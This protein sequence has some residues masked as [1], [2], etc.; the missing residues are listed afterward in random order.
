[1]WSGLPLLPAPPPAVRPQPVPQPWSLHTGM[2]N[3]SGAHSHTISNISSPSS[4]VCLLLPPGQL[5]PP[6]V[7]QERGGGGGDQ[8]EDAPLLQVQE[9]GGQAVPPSPAPLS[10]ENSWR[11]TMSPG[12]SSS[13][14]VLPGQSSGAVF[15]CIARENER[16]IHQVQQV[17]EELSSPG[18]LSSCWRQVTD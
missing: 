16:L 14:S 9:E 11:G 12:W 1:M 15:Q 8:G 18:P 10:P 4:G 17:V 2:P 7:G 3:S 6:G 5:L 13:T